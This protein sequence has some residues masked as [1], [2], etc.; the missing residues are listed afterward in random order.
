MTV[1][2]YVTKEQITEYTKR[3]LWDAV[4]LCDYLDRWAR[5]YPD[6]EALIEINSGN[7]LTWA[8][9]KIMS[10]RLALNF[11]KMGI[12]KG[13]IV[14]VQ[15]P[16]S[17]EFCCINMGLA[18]IGAVMSPVVMPWRK[19]ELNHVLELTQCVA[20]IVP[21]DVKGFDHAAMMLDLQAKHHSL[22]QIII[23]G[24]DSSREGTVSLKSLWENRLEEEHPDDY[25]NQYKADANDI[26]T[27]CMTSGTEA[28]AKGVPRTHNHW[29][30]LVRGFIL[31][32][33]FN[34][35]DRTIMALPLPNLF[36]LTAGVYPNIIMGETLILL[37]G[38]DPVLMAKTIGEEKATV[39]AGVPAMHVA[40]LNIPELEQYDFFSLRMVLTGGAPC[41]TSV[42]KELMEKLKCLVVNG[43]GSNEG[44]FVGT[45]LGQ[46]AE[47]VSETI[48][49]Q[50]PLYDIKI[51]DDEGY[52]VPRGEQ[53]EICGKGPGIFAGYYKRPDLTEKSFT[54]E[55]YYRSGDV[56]YLGDDGNYRFVTRKKDMIIRGGI[57]ISAEEI[58]FILYE[59]PKIFNVA[60]IGMPDE[61]LG[62]RM[63]IIVEKKPDVEELTLEEIIAFM[64]NLGVAKYKWPERLEVVDQLPR[65]PTGKVLKYAL[66]DDI[67]KK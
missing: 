42:I 10:D 8:Q 39:Y 5:C 18:R 7:R 21:G 32:F 19:H 26:I 34:L 64:E 13:D 58:E 29:K 2:N 60:A 47:E 15:I 56:G 66:R 9:Y 22:K 54:S 38:F 51:L 53:G 43:Y 40:M 61:R 17:I 57:N 37:D 55:G 12:K 30:S 4:S 33:G 24:E 14:M 44:I 28:Q 65:T 23:Y 63:C 25:I 6:K 46:T 50:T 36:A 11:I 31:N 45:Q 62:E 3:G 49:P 1:E 20:A 48:G 16:N 52:E 27:I 41:P 59:H 67:A 35:N